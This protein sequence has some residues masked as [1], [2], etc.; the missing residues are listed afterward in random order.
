MDPYIWENGEIK[1]L[2][3][4]GGTNPFGLYSG[5]TAGLNE[6]GEV[7]GTLTLA[8]DQVSHAFLWDGQQLSDLGT[9]GGNYAI[10]YGINE[11]GD[12]VGFS[13]L[14]GDNVFHAFLYRNGVMTDLGTVDND[15]C[16]TSQYANSMDQVVGSSQASDGMGSCVNPYTHAFLWENGGPSVDLNLLIPPNSA[17]H[18]TVADYITDSGEIVGGGDPQGCDD[19]DTCNHTYVLIPCDDNHP[20]IDG[21]DYST[22]D[23]AALPEVRTLPL[24]PSDVTNESQGAPAGL[25]G[26][27]RARPMFRHRLA[28]TQPPNS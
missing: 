7:A 24:Q 5:L 12:V 21:C 27:L 1:D 28:R 9:L 26:L 14:P 4:F 10:A 8:G 23:S 25:R 2:G 16:S 17:L 6:R 11:L 15:A 13:T 22:V 20:A 19:N 18:L 3:N